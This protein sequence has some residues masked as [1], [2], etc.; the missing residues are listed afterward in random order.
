[1]CVLAGHDRTGPG[2][3][4]PGRHAGHVVRPVQ[5]VDR[6]SFQQ[7]VVEHRLRPLAGFLRRPEQHADGAVERT[8][9][10]QGRGRAEDHRHVAVV[11]AGVHAAVVNGGE[12]EAAA[13]RDRQRVELAA[14]AEFARES[15]AQRRADVGGWLREKP[16][17]NVGPSS[18]VCHAGSTVSR[19]SGRVTGVTSTATPTDY[20]HSIAT[21]VMPS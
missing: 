10:G 16:E 18:L 2:Q 12:V 21:T 9:L 11:A 4:V 3:Q 19:V 17:A 8:V 7:P 20:R 14:Q 6:E 15:D 13:F 1:M 5:P